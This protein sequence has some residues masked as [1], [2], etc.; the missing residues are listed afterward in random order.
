MADTFS[1]G[2]RDV[3]RNSFC[4]VLS[5]AEGYFDFGDSAREAVG[6]PEPIATVPRGALNGLTSLFCDRIPSP[7]P[8]GPPPPFTGGQCPTNYTVEVEYT[9]IF[10]GSPEGG[11]ATATPEL[12][13]IGQA[14][15][16][17]PAAGGLEIYLPTG[18]GDVLMV[19]R[20]GFPG[21]WVNPEILN[22]SVVR[23]DGLP[24]DCGDPPPGSTPDPPPGTDTPIPDDIVVGP[25]GSEVVIPI[26]IVFSGPLVNVNGDFTIGFNIE[27][28]EFSIFGD[29]NLTTGDIN[30]N[31][32]GRNPDNEKCCLPPDVDDDDTDEEGEEEDDETKNNIVGVLVN[33]TVD[34]SVI[35][36][37]F[38]GQENGPDF[39]QPRIANIYFLLRL[40][41][42]I[43]WTE[44]ISA[45]HPNQY[46]QCPVDFGAIR[47]VASPVE[48]VSI[49]LTPIRRNI[50]VNEFPT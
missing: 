48:G 39:Y 38:V 19:G 32:G 10:G 15:A 36:A 27:N 47:V 30:F 37:T 43:F 18:A 7:I 26:T 16:V 40:K 4:N 45:K 20:G 11:I 46:I 24:D 9:G 44:P 23:I 33:G 31:F 21:A 6:F 17:L 42:Q 22:Q 29:I 28:P 3:V 50:S 2:V 35:K 1:D 41:G 13:P 8:D 12:G 49:R 34:N 5:V 14:Y 25:P